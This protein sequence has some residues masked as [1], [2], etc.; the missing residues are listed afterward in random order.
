VQMQFLDSNHISEGSGSTRVNESS[1]DAAHLRDLR[2]LPMTIVS[3]PVIVLMSVLLP[4]PV[5]PN[6]AMRIGSIL[7]LLN[8][9]LNCARSNSSAQ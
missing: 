8:M 3:S 2:P 4:A 6:T 7:F 5:T 9:L 1:H